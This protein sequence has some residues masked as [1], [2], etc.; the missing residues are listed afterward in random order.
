FYG[1]LIFIA[2]AVFVDYKL[3]ATE[4]TANQ[5]KNAIQSLLYW[6]SITLLTIAFLYVAYE[7]DWFG[8]FQSQDTSLTSWQAVGLFVSGFLLEQSLSLDNIFVIAFLLKYFQVP[9]LN[10][11][12]VLSIG[13]WTAIILRG[14]MIIAG[15]W[16]INNISWIIYVLGI[17]LIYS[18]IKIFRTDPNESIDPN[19][20][21]V[22]KL[23]RKWFPITKDYFGGHFIVRKM[24]KWALT[25]LFI[26]LVAIE[27]TDILFAIDSIPAIFALT[28]DP[29]I[30]LSSNIL[31]VAN[32]RAM[33]TILSKILE[34]LEYIHYGLSILLV[35][36]GLKIIACHYIHI[37][38][39][40]NMII[41]VVVL[42]LG[43]LYSLWRSSKEKKNLR[44]A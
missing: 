13:I 7:K 35:F 33:F 37:E 19:Q 38:V 21:I 23:I 2:L 27:F 17:V 4:N 9:I 31:A 3:F 14:F 20:N 24:G 42:G 29:F 1:Y 11:S 39:W 40:V 5:H 41:I 32:L 30:V 36:I 44:D 6:I 12:G 15:L 28:T 18:G 8:G 22:I 25:P 10:Q 26:T 34:K 43:I 16:L